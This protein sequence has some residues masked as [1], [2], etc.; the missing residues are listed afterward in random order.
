MKLWTLAELAGLASVAILTA[1]CG[2][3]GQPTQLSESDIRTAV[4]AT[5]TVR[6]TLTAQVPGQTDTPVPPSET[7]VAA[8]PSDTPTQTPT[9]TPTFTP[10]VTATQQLVSAGLV[11]Y[12]PLDDAPAPGGIVK[13]QSGQGNDAT[14]MGQPQLVTPGRFGGA[15]RFDGNSYLALAHSPTANAQAFSVSLWFKT[16]DPSQD[17][18]LAS[19]ATWQ[20]SQGSGW[21]MGTRLS[22][23]WSADH[24]RLMTDR[25]YRQYSPLP[26][27]WNHLVLTYDRARFRE[28]VNG[29]LSLDCPASGQPPGADAGLEVGAWMPLKPF[30]YVGLIDDFR[31]YARALSPAEVIDLYAPELAAGLNDHLLAYYSFDQPAASVVKDDSGN[32]NDGAISG[33]SGFEPQGRLGGAFAFNGSNLVTMRSNPTAGL[34]AWGVTLWFKTDHPERD[35]KLATAASLVRAGVGSGWTIG[36]AFSEYWDGNNQPLLTN[37]CYRGARPKAGE[38]NHLAVT[39]DGRRLQEYLN[40]DAVLDC[41]TTQHAL[42]AGRPL[43]VGGWSAVPGFNYTGLLDEFRVYGRALSA[44]EVRLLMLTGLQ[45]P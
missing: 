20:N 44:D 27:T 1:A 9:P 18:K 11:V 31:I 43:E 25:C 10:T 22:E 37:P 16:D 34:T 24:A 17:L 36:T 30:N 35:T 15:Y 38:W 26:Q 39:S 2:G 28:Y 29:R 5:I 45:Q 40:G 8:V 12:Y 14:V 19:A 41:P 6:R 33:T 42:G 13:D 3:A 4:A 21:L 7:P 23:G 32:G